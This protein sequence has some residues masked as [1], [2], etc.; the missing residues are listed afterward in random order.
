MGY[1]RGRNRQSFIKN[2]LRNV[3]LAL[4]CCTVAGLCIFSAF[5]PI[6]S[7]KYHVSLPKIA[8]AE[9]DA[10]RVHYLSVGNGDCTLIEFPDGQNALVGGGPDDGTARK[11]VFRFLNALKIKT[12]D[13]VVV[14]DPTHQGV[15]VLT[16]LLK[17]Y[18]VEAAYLPTDG[19]TNSAYTSFVAELQRQDVP[20]R[21]ICFGGLIEGD[22]YN[23]RILYPLLDEKSTS[24]AVLTLEYGNTDVLLWSGNDEG[25]YRV[26]T[27]E[28]QLHLLEKWGV[29]IDEFDVIQVDT[30]ADTDLLAG[31]VQ[32]F[33]CKHAIFSC[34]GG[35][36]NSPKAE[37]LQTLGALDVGI[38][39]TDEDGHV[40]LTMTKDGYKIE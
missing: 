18:T 21:D 7:W 17:Y 34:G 9:E 37:V 10:L 20:T 16:E 22:G 12:L 14:P 5:V 29:V 2:T 40:T 31:F 19:G 28:K 3:L 11:N 36:S 32:E 6:D 26:L 27:T 15:G 39:R 38:S 8:K 33:S 23:L 25:V 4:T 24:E 35:K 13:A 1:K 30:L